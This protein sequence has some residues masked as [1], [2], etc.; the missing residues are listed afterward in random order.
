ME[1]ESL[2]APRA[3]PIGDHTA[4]KEAVMSLIRRTRGELEWPDTLLGRRLFDWPETWTSL[5]ES[6][7]K[8][9]EYEEEGMMVVRAEMPGIDP[10]RDVEITVADGLLRIKAE[11]RQE[12]KVEEKKGFRSEFQYGA[13]T[14]SVA[15]PAGVTANDVAASYTDGILEVRL[16]MDRGHAEARKIPVTRS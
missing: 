8:V 15:L 14:R 7:P 10:D 6:L 13:F 1:A 4:R 2:L 5:E 3:G 11:R 9:E 16:P 12:T